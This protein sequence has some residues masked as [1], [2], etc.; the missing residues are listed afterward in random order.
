MTMGEVVEILIRLR[1]GYDLSRRE[2]DAVCYACNIL[3]Q[4]PRLYDAEKTLQELK[5]TVN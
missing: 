4:F 2:D 5:N 1:D 3:D